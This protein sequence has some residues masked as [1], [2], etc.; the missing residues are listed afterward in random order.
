RVFV[1]FAS[2]PPGELPLPQPSPPASCPSHSSSPIQIGLT[3]DLTTVMSGFHAALPKA[4]I[5][6]ATPPSR[7]C[8]ACRQGA[9]TSDN[10]PPAATDS[11]G[12]FNHTGVKR[13]MKLQRR[14]E[15]KRG[16]AALSVL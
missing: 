1:G 16:V 2:T 4:H 5:P 8:A 6:L 15:Q 9:A 7:S 11:R 12:A 14:A 10:S 3:N 13:G